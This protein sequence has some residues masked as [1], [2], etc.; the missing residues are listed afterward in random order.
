MAGGQR[1]FFS[2]LVFFPGD[3]PQRQDGC[4]QASEQHFGVSAYGGESPEHG[5]IGILCSARRV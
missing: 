4:L 5:E 3:S 1:A 2:P